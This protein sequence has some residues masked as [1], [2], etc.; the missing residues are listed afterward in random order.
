MNWKVRKRKH[1]HVI[2]EDI[3]QFPWREGVKKNTQRLEYFGNSV[4]DS[5]K[6]PYK[7]KAEA[8]AVEPNYSVEFSVALWPRQVTSA[9]AER[10]KINNRV[11]KA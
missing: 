11:L 3:P 2:S 8:S 10:Q 6:T 4:G 9:S 5:N 7:C 1:S